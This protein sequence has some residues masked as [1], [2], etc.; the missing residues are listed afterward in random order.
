MTKSSPGSFLV[1]VIDIVKHLPLVLVLAV[2]CAWALDTPSRFPDSFAHP[3]STIVSYWHSMLEHRHRSALECFA[4]GSFADVDQMLPLPE[5]VE[6]RCRD[7]RLADRGRGTVDVTYTVEYRVAMGDSLAWF[8]TGD[9]MNFTNRG[10]KI[11]RP[12][13][14]AEDRH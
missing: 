12:L 14:V 2:L 6:L 3:Q 11:D 1:S 8:E 5:L 7:F 10:W 13:F 4:Y 9:R